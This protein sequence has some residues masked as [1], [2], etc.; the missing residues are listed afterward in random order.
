M[1]PRK[2]SDDEALFEQTI[3]SLESQVTNVGAHLTVDTQARL[4]YVQ[5]IKQM[6]DRL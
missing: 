1:K 5:E 3:K 6:S 2:V 4:L